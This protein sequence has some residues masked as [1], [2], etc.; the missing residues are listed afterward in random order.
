MSV[1]FDPVRLRPNRRRIDPVVVGIIV[2]L[3]GIAAAVVKP[4]EG[5]RQAALAATTPPPSV[6][7]ATPAATSPPVGIVPQP[8]EPAGP[9]P[10]TW[11]DMAPAVTE[12]TGWG[13][14]AMVVGPPAASDA[15]P[16]TGFLEL[17]S[18]SVVA[19]GGS[20][21]AYIPR[22]Q[23]SIVALGV[24]APKGAV[25]EDVRIWRVHDD[26]RLEWVDAHPVTGRR[27]DDPLLMIQPASGGL[28]Y[29]SWTGGHYRI[30]VLT[31]TGIHRIAIE[32]PGRFGNV[33]DPDPWPPA[34]G[35]LVA[36]RRGDPSVTRQGLFV[37]VD[38]VSVD[39]PATAG[40]T[41]DEA[42]EWLVELRQSGDETPNV[43]V[44]HL[45]RATGLGVMFTEHAVVSSATIRR[46]APDSLA[47]E[48][49]SFGGVSS[50]HGRTPYLVFTP[51]GGAAWAPGVYAISSAWT[52]PAGTHSGTWYIELRPGAL[53]GGPA[54]VTD[55]EPGG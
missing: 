6:A 51:T 50:L 21:S 37:I 52:D 13:V 46:L 20:E 17:W 26:D 27:A 34:L 3:V 41:L 36:A 8:V 22:D 23:Q 29:T 7:A 25:A 24:T 53:A 19:G 55:S 15:P 10:P 45:P 54:A 16:A 39:L 49:P 38:G 18:P 5:D 28:A 12:H 43:A 44:A 9:P 2:V 31:D 40:P 30:D 1:D 11:S 14:A 42:G 35:D 4:W 32:I 48:T 47:D 33:P